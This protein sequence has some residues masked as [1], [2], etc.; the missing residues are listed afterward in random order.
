MSNFDEK[1][2]TISSKIFK[3]LNESGNF[4][5]ISDTFIAGICLANDCALATFNKKHFERVKKL[6]IV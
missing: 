1:A 4:I 3:E 6:K 2:A 5:G